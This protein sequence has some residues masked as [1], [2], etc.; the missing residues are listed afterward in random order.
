MAVAAIVASASA[1]VFTDANKALAKVGVTSGAPPVVAAKALLRT[2]GPSTFTSGGIFLDRSTAAVATASALFAGSNILTSLK[3]L[4]ATIQS[5]IDN[6][7]TSP[8]PQTFATASTIRTNG[9]TAKAKEVIGAI[10]NLVG[11]ADVSG[12]NLISSTAR[13]IIIQTTP[14]GGRLTVTPL[15]LDAT[16]LDLT[17]LS[18]LSEAE[19]TEAL[20]KVQAAITTAEAR[21]TSLIA[22]Q[23]SLGLANSINQASV[24]A[25]NAGNVGILPLGS[26]INQVA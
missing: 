9:A 18:V 12:A 1:L 5:A 7:L 23:I 19:A 3:A 15:P 17:G 20:A 10:N 8:E 21:I 26:L 16:G 14:F 2:V 25:I 13:D 22:L 11:S 4:Q 6:G 24:V